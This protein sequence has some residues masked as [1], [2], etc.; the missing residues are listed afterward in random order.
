[1][2]CFCENK[3]LRCLIFLSLASLTA[4]SPRGVDPDD[5]NVAEE[6]T[7]LVFLVLA[8]ASFLPSVG[9]VGE[10]RCGALLHCGAH[11][12][13]GR[14]WKAQMGKVINLD[15]SLLFW[16]LLCKTNTYK[17]ITDNLTV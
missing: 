12:R 16:K 13:E 10:L 11:N 4:D 9:R 7:F 5:A 1:M 2:L 15:L 14:G 3:P 8:R 6:N 17:T